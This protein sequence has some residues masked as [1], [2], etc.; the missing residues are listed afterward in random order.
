[1]TLQDAPSSF[2]IKLDGG[3][4]RV[5]SKFLEIHIAARK[6]KW[7]ISTGKRLHLQKMIQAMMNGRLKMHLS[8]LAY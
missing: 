7:A 8:N 2:H 5:W 6:K 3:N 4:Y 1:M